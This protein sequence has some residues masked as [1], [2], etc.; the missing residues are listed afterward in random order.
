MSNRKDHRIMERRDKI[1]KLVLQSSTKGI[2]AVEIAK[3]LGIHKTVVYRDLSSLNLMG[4]VE[5]DQGI[6]RAKTGEQ[7][8]KP[9]EKEIVIELPIPKNQLNYVARLAAYNVHLER[10]GY[11]GIVEI[12]KAILEKFDEARTIRIKGKNVDDLELQKIGNLIRE[13]TAKSSKFNLRGLFK[14]LKLRLDS[15]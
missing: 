5:S 8:I 10:I 7:K 3:R 4:R 2:R 9:L 6:W 15:K 11:S 1:Y 12:N 14:S 13:A